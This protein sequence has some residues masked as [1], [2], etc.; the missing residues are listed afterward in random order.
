MLFA[1]WEVCIVCITVTEVLKMLCSLR[2]H[3]QVRG[4]FF[5]IRTDPKLENNFFFS[6]LWNEK[7]KTTQG[8]ETQASVTVTLVRENNNLDRAKNQS[9]C[10]ICYHAHLEKIIVYLFNYLK[11]WQKFYNL[12]KHGSMHI[13]NMLPKGM[14]S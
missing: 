14:I 12:W 9:D 13:Y 6:K 11:T 7:Q 5:T 4:Q 8:K 2:Q 10:R 1:G 3:Y